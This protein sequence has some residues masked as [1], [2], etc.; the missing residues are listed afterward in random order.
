M[1]FYKDKRFIFLFC[2][3]LIFAAAIA[4]VAGWLLMVALLFF[5]FVSVMWKEPHIKLG[6]IIMLVLLALLNIAVHNMNFGIDF[7]GGTRIPVVLEHSVDSTTMNELVQ[8]IKSRA[9]TLG[10]KEVK[11]RAVGNSLV[12]VEI[13]STDEATIDFIE[14]TL[15]QQGV[16]LGVVDGK[17]AVSGDHIFRTS[18]RPL[19]SSE[20]VRQGADWGVA[21]SVDREG[22]EMFAQAAKNKAD[23]PIY[24]FLDRPDD[25]VLFYQRDMLKKYFYPDSGEKESIRALSQM[26]SLDGDRNIS[27]YL[28]EDMP[29]NL[30]PR[31][32]R[33]KALVSENAPQSF[34][35]S[36][37]GMGFTVVSLNES[38]M[39]VEFGRTRSGVLIVNKLEA[40]GLLTA[41]L[42]GGQITTGVPNYNY[43]VTGS[44]NASDA[45][46][47]AQ[48]ATARVKSIESILKGGALPV[49]IS[50]GSRT[51]LP[52]ALGSEFLKL[53]L[54]AIA[55]SLIIISILI[56]IRYRN[57]RATAPIV[58]ISL[59][60]LVVL[61][62]ILGS[63]TIDL[64]AMAGIIAA[65]GV[66]VDAQIVITDETLKKDEH[67]AHE[68]VEL[69][70]GIIRT[71]AIVAIFSMVPLLF[72]G[73]VEI[74]GFAMSTML[75]A[76]L[77]YLITRPAYAAI[78][79][80][81]LEAERK[82]QAPASAAS[83]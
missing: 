70:F 76:L 38:R 41:P 23:Y 31:T 22:A 48:E 44:V 34:K 60:E 14:K 64:A 27:V 9:S 10:L 54:I 25:A 59:A 5:G 3:F 12:N 56:G 35:D 65:I 17:V 73:L 72:S 2:M 79:E 47:K 33:T 30:T 20:L 49:Q 40:A 24:M 43:I 21:F 29:A 36:L 19:G 8:T 51:T 80:K 74:I 66:G 45:K 71:N 77:G 37:A 78:L 81:V 15:S 46:T 28:L 68:K 16:Y 4:A 69:A 1:E 32:N 18:I 82:G 26:L 57:I 53:S 11:A 7:V 50:L 61:L 63:F 42:L 13:A 75:G 6:S 39:A 83:E 62:S 58:L 67:T 55:S 52:A